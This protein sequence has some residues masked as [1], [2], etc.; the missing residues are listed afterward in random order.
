MIKGSYS[1]D[2]RSGTDMSETYDDIYYNG[3]PYES[4]TRQENAHGINRSNNIYAGFNALYRTEKTVITH[5]VA[6]QWHE[7]PGSLS[8]GTVAYSPGIIASD[9]M[10]ARSAS[11][12]LSPSLEGQY[13]FI[14]SQKW[15]LGV[16]WNL[17]HSHNDDISSYEDSGL[18]PIL[19]AS[20]ENIY[21][22][23][24]RVTAVWRPKNI[25]AFQIAL[26]ENRSVSDAD[27]AGE[28]TSGQ[29][30]NN[31]TTM[32]QLMGWWKISNRIVL[33]VKP[34][35]TL[36]DRNINH[37][38]KK[39]EWLPGIN[40][41]VS[42]MI[43]AK[44][45]IDLDSWYYLRN[46]SP[47]QGNDLILRSTELKWIEGNP[48]VKSS[49]NYWLALTYQTYPTT[50]LNSILSLDLISNSNVS[51]LSYRPGGRDYDGVIGQ[52]QNADV[53]R[54]YQAVWDLNTHL[55]NGHLRIGNQFSYSYQRISGN[56]LGYARVR[57][58]VSWDFGNCNLCANYGSPEKIMSDGGTSIVRTSPYY[59]LR[60]SYG[61]GNL[62]F[63][64]ELSAPFHR[65]LHT[66]TIFNSGPYHYTARNRENGRSVSLSLTYTFDYGK[67]VT[68]G[69]DIY[70]QSIKSSSVLGA[71]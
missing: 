51:Y 34:Q 35:I 64:A 10:T 39:T 42:W 15:N 6:L 52:Y 23:G 46:P 62:L 47:S 67:K 11:H 12:S 38:I 29:W 66:S 22:I 60:F 31:G 53:R 41:N 20:R 1:R 61:N 37:D 45:G 57:P 2:H 27:Y 14:P 58:Y 59:N 44:N 50:W 68:P 7:N 28:V 19:T 56:G 48:D 63:D 17:S 71:E 25:L 21:H 24:A 69:V 33:T 36:Y 13:T 70:E 4:V 18:D 43:N 16:N 49:S 55:L 8:R 9:M 40:A 3:T 5:S 26:Q 32:L 30:Q 65:Y 54:N